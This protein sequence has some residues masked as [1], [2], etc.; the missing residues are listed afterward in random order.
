MSEENRGPGRP[1]K[2]PKGKKIG[3]RCTLV[4]GEKERFD[5]AKRLADMSQNEFTRA[6]V[7][8]AVDDVLGIKPG[9]PKP[10]RKK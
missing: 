5:E 8:H 9:T 6:A 2:L 3:V 4:N 10:K 7:M 1:P